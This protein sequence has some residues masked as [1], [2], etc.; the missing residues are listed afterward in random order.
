MSFQKGISNRI[1][2]FVKNQMKKKN[3]QASII[4]RIMKAYQCRRDADV[5]KHLGVEKGAVSNY[6]NGRRKLPMSLVLKVAE[7]TSMSLDWLMLGKNSLPAPILSVHSEQSS[8]TNE[9]QF[10]AGEYRPV[11]LLKDEIAAGSPLEIRE[12]D[13]EGYCL[14]QGSGRNGGQSEHL[15]CCRIRGDSMYPI[16]SDGDIVAIDHSQKDPRTLHKKMAAFRQNSGATVKWLSYISKDVVLG[17]PENK[18]EIEHTICLK[19]E[20]INTGIIGKVSWWMASR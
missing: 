20:E 10:V 19:G 3:L 17:I 18:N 5:A 14:V 16:L 6:R 15:T 4:Q 13:V 11:R 9:R 12:D 1:R 2:S 8:F 7:E